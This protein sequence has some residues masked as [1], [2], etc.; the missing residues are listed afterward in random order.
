[1]SQS[2]GAR[3][4]SRELDVGGREV[5]ADDVAAGLL[6]GLQRAG[7]RAAGDVGD[8]RARPAP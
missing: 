5:D 3:R 7:T 1:V 2:G 8:E 6:G 4:R